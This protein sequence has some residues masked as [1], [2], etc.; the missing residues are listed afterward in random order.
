MF[1]LFC[2]GNRFYVMRAE[3]RAHIYK[4]RSCMNAF[5]MESQSKLRHLSFAVRAHFQHFY[6]HFFCYYSLHFHLRWPDS[7]CFVYR[8]KNYQ[9][10]AYDR[11]SQ[12]K[13]T[14]NIDKRFFFWYRFEFILTFHRPPSHRNVRLEGEKSE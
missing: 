4:I 10:T 3:R 1:L 14:Q 12:N 5:C 2:F 13:T 7:S 8:L 11:Y 6:T 9:L